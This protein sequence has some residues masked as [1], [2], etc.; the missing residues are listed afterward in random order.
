[1]I[2]LNYYNFIEIDRKFYEQPAFSVKNTYAN[3]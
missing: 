3:T 1:M 2:Y